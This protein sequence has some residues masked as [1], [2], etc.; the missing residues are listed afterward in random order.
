MPLAAILDQEQIRWTRVKYDLG[1]SLAESGDITVTPVI[2]GVSS[3]VS[4]VDSPDASYGMTGAF[5]ASASFADSPDVSASATAAFSG[6]IS[7]AETPG[8]TF[9]VSGAV[10]AVI[11][12]P[13]SPDLL[14]S[15]SSITFTGNISLAATTS[16]SVNFNSL[17][18]KNYITMSVTFT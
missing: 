13:I 12:L 6:A 8:Q 9:S 18:A 15:V 11:S 14:W 16:L 7:L 4:L 1:V 10:G 3:T 5:S 17:T 2:S